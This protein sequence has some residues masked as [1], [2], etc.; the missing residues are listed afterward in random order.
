LCVQE[1]IHVTDDASTESAL[2]SQRREAEAFNAAEA[3]RAWPPIG[4]HL[5]IRS[6]QPQKPVVKN[7]AT[8]VAV[9]SSQ[10]ALNI[11]FATHINNRHRL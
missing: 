10:L 4:R 8:A 5:S 9:E 1:N 7:V 3:H 11:Y 2:D 6:A